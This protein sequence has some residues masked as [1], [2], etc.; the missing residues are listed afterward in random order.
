MLEGPHPGL[1]Q[2]ETIPLLPPEGQGPRKPWKVLRLIRTGQILS[3]AI[4]L[5]Q[6]S[7]PSVSDRLDSK[8]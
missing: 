2:I 3:S 4:S 8:G 5:Q 6:G 1:G 7:Q